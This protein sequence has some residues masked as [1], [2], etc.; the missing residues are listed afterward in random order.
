ML[1]LESR[2]VNIG[3]RDVGA[4]W[5]IAVLVVAGFLL[6]SPPSK[7]NLALTEEVKVGQAGRVLPEG[8]ADVARPSCTT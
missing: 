5:V 6:Q 8:V 3:S 1:N 7:V 2:Q 4:A